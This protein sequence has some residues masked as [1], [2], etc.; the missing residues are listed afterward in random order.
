MEFRG[1]RLMFRDKLCIGYIPGYTYDFGSGLGLG[2]NATR[3]VAVFRSFWSG[4][5][6]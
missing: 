1:K 4:S 3:S 6:W 2:A 5:I